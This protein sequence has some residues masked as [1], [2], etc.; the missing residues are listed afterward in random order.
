MSK[1]ER[2]VLEK[3]LKENNKNEN[4]TYIEDSLVVKAFKAGLEAAKKK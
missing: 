1:E 3:F 2:E 4:S